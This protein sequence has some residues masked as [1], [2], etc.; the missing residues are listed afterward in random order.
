MFSRITVRHIGSASKALK[1]T[2]KSLNNLPLY[3]EP[4]KWKGLPAETIFSLYKERMVKL[5]SEY[6]PC[7]EEL[8]ALISTSEHTGVSPGNIKNLYY[9][10]EQAAIDINGGEGNSD[11]VI[12]P[13]E[14]DELPSPAQDLVDQHREQRFYNRLAAYE[15]PLLAQFR[16]EYKPPSK[17][18]FP[19]TYRYTTYIGEEHPAEKKVVLRV[20]SSSLGLNSKQLHKFRLLAKTRYDHITDVFKMSTER[21]P[22]A[23]QNARYL[24]DVLQ[25]LLKEAKDISKDDFS[26]V[27][28]DT[29]HTTAKMLRKK[30]HNYKFPEE[31]NRPEDAPQKTINLAH[32][33]QKDL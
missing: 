19:V 26:D 31:W 10:G 14:Y 6:K 24:N 8:D 32:I 5:G 18:Q 7:K 17:K 4:A 27:P 33:F 12:Q 13:F 22:E 23:S 29:R 9:K 16:Q 25:K 3:T 2:P 11:E 1:R 15:L 30:K 28:L 21:F 20:N